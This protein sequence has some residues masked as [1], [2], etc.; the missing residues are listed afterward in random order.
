[1]MLQNANNYLYETSEKQINRMKG[2]RYLKKADWDELEDF[3]P[4]KPS[5]ATIT[6]D[7]DFNA[8]AEGRRRVLEKEK[9]S[10]WHQFKNGTLDPKSTP[11]LIEDIDKLLDL[12]GKV[13]LAE[14]N[15][16]EQSWQAPSWMIKLSK[17]AIFKNI[18]KKML[19]KRLESSYDSAVGFISAQDECLSLLNSMARSEE[20]P[21]NDLKTLEQEINENKIEGQSFV[22]NLRTNFPDIYE[23]VSTTQA[24]RH[25]LRYEEQTIERLQKKGRI[26]A[27]EAE[28]MLNSLNERKK[29]MLQKSSN[30][31]KSKSKL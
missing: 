9:S 22:R 17:S 16:L 26:D 13:S 10:Y 23:S 7:A 30:F 6:D 4:S 14:R 20:L 27:G 1:M 2:N 25:L 21:E 31:K 5:A 3:L 29:K 24:I 18:G 19:L 12:G 15:D 8:L 28:K 11:A